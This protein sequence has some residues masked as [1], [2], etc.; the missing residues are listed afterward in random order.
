MKV[1]DGPK[2]DVEGKDDK[3]DEERDKSSV[4]S[5]SNKLHQP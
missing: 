5:L 3:S 4:A 2:D 1:N